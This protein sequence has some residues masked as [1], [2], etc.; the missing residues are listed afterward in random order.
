MNLFFV[1]WGKG[2][3]TIDYGLAR[4]RVD[5]VSKAIGEFINYINT[6]YGLSPS[7]SCC[8]GFSLGAHICGL[9]HVYVTDGKL[10]KVY[11]MYSPIWD[12]R[13]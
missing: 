1:D 13:I 6:K 12:S 3:K 11:G 9:V 10:N 7:N 5:G 8:I 2:A 4:S